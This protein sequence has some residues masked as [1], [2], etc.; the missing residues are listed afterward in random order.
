[1]KRLEENSDIGRCLEPEEEKR[2]L[3]AASVNPSRL[4][5][6]VSDDSRLD[7]HEV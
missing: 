3:D 1:M 4:I 6:P 7:R 2:L 5:H